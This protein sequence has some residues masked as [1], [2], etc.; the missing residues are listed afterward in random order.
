MIEATGVERDA[1]ITPG[2]LGLYCGENERA[3]ARVVSVFKSVARIPI[4]IQLGHAGRK[5]SSHLP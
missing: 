4:G 2:C 3:L 1:R 5:A